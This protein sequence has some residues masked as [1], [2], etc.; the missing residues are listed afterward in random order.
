MP[1]HATP[2]Q[3]EEV[4]AVE[5]TPGELEAIKQ[6]MKDMDKVFEAEKK[7]KFKIELFFSRARSL[8]QPTPGAMSFWESGSKLHGGGDAKIYLCPG[9][10]LG[11]SDCSSFILDAGNAS[12]HLYCNKCRTM[13]K[14]EE[15]IGEHMAVLTMKKWAEVFLYYYVRLEHDAD[16][17]I[18]YSP[19]DIRTVT[20]LEQAK[21]MGGEA[22]EK[23]RGKRARGVYPL[24]RIIKDTSA[25]ADLLGR[26]HAFLTA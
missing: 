9:K 12:S 22:L 5:M 25:G 3:L 1:V 15:V 18:K 14:G 11:K 13:W 17:V 26:F 23:V 10:K 8:W 16:L 24:N 20:M 4:N 6:R 21:S 19:D 7:G 2:I